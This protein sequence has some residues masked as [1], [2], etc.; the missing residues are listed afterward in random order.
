M[1][2]VDY[3]SDSE[4]S[5]S[6][7]SVASDH[8]RKEKAGRDPGPA[9]KRQKKLSDAPSSSSKKGDLPPLPS[10]FHDLYASTVRL[11]N[12]DD[13]SLHQGRRRQIPHIV[14]NWPSHLYI[15]WH[16]SGPEHKALSSLLATLS[17]R[18]E[19]NGAGAEA[20][21]I[22][23]FLTSDLGAPLPLHISLSRPLSL[24]TAR[25]DD[26]LERVRDAVSRSGVRAFELAPDGL[27]WHRTHESA[28]SF[29]VLRVRSCSST[30]TSLSTSTLGENNARENADKTRQKNMELGTL[31]RHCNML[32]KSF[33]QPELYA[34]KPTEDQGPARD[35]GDAFHVSVAWSFSEPTNEL[36]RVTQDVFQTIQHGKAMKELRIRVDG[37]KAKIG[38]TITHL[39]LAVAGNGDSKGPRK[40]RALF[41]AE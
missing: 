39:P 1:A 34:F 6:P 15:E 41:H 29:L 14:G 5:S 36:K 23:G 33:D 3:D 9:S 24:P 25:K 16:P 4:S 13:P 28:R 19:S 20:I 40:R 37:I 11:S 22:H 12:T 21:K 27:E 26:F 32:C 30:A 31:L 17:S 7:S 10:A 8:S 38:N 35:V 2:L 18:L